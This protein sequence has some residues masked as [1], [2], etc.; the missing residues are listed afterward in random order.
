MTTRWVVDVDGLGLCAVCQLDDNGRAQRVG[1]PGT[2][3]ACDRLVARLRTK[4]AART[5]DAR[6]RNGQ[7]LA[8][9][10]RGGAMA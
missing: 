3:Q 6:R 8:R 1:D 2:R 7:R 9:T 10:R 5:R 4:D